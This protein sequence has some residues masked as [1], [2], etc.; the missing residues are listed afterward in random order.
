MVITPPNSVITLLLHCHFE[1]FLC[2][3]EKF[4]SQSFTKETLFNYK[5]HERFYIYIAFIQNE[6]FKF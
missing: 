2:G 4:T 5:H 3:F 1:N 6:L